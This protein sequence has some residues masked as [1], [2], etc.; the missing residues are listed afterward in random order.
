M[1]RDA[2]LNDLHDI[3]EIYN[4]AILHTTAIYDYKAHTIEER[5]QWYEKK[6]QEGYPIIVFEENSKV[7]GFATFGSFRPWPAFKYTIE[8]SIYVHEKYSNKG[9]G[10]TLL[11]E[12]I[13]ICDEREFATMVAGID[14]S[15]ENS[16]KMHEKLGFKYS[17]TINKAGYK[18]EK[19]L[20]LVFYQLELK[21]PNNPLE[22]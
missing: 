15:N 7:I 1:I 18:F 11:K 16:I 10:T 17:G 14:G 12:I 8:H 3:L 13:R 9:I 6:I 22:N 20:N 5:I 21:G 19:W 2:N 4:D